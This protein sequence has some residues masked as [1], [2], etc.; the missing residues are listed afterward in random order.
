MM[1]MTNNLL[2]A[3]ESPLKLDS[4]FFMYGKAISGHFKG[5]LNG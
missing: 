4:I 2:L 3:G 1:I 5:I